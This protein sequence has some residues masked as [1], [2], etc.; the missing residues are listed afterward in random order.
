VILSG[1]WE[2]NQGNQAGTVNSESFYVEI[3]PYSY[4]EILTTEYNISM[5]GDSS[6]KITAS[7]TN[8]G[9]IKSEIRAGVDSSDEAIEIEIEE[10]DFSISPFQKAEIEFTL[11]EKKN[12]NG[13][14]T[15]TFWVEEKEQ[16][17]QGRITR[18]FAVQ[19]KEKKFALKDIPFIIPGIVILTLALLI[20]LGF[21]FV[22]RRR[23]RRREFDTDLDIEV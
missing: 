8:T 2:Y 16:T 21:L 12:Q 14:Y 18:D 9:N 23:N 3:Q 19:A 7:V 5:S 1:T 6:T 13:L 11:T 4:L 17:N 20:V 22:R 15:V 10:T